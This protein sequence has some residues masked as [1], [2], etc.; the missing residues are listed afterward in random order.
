MAAILSVFWRIVCLRDSPAALPA[1]RV[2][3]GL[4][5][6]AALG[7]ALFKGAAVFGPRENVVYALVDA[8]TQLGFLGGLLWWRARGRRFLQSATALGGANAL[9]YVL[10]LPAYWVV[11]SDAW[12]RDSAWVVG[13]ALFVFGVMVYGVMVFGHILRAA[14]DWSTPPAMGAALVYAVANIWLLNVYLPGRLA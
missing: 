10:S 9:L 3:F 1:S 11:V 7:L 4:A 8:A 5:W 6:A 2:L 14:L 12:P 13:A